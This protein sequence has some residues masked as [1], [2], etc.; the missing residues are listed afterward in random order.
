L[1]KVISGPAGAAQDRS[2]SLG[3]DAHGD[4]VAVWAHITGTPSAL[5]KYADFLS[6]YYRPDAVIK[7]AGS[8]AYT[9]AK[10]YNTSALNQSVTANV[11]RGHA[12]TFDIKIVNRSSVIDAALIKGPGSKSG[13]AVRYLAGASGTTAITN[14]VVN[15]S[16]TLANIPPGG[17]KIFRLVVTVNAGTAVGASNNWLIA[18]TSAHDTTRK[19]AVNAIVNVAP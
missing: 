17:S 8:T 16:Y 9:G 19:D 13:F 15:G 1:A 12:T 11:Q 5:L 14:A 6:A 2:P 4:G 10:I 3:F 18:A 7:K